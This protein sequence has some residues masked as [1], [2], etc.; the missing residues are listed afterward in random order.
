MLLIQEAFSPGAGRSGV[1]AGSFLA[2]ITIFVDKSARP[3]VCAVQKRS[4]IALS[5]S[6]RIKSTMP[7]PSVNTNKAS[8]APDGHVQENLLPA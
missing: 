4:S 7:C 3:S 8:V 2:E 5:A 6:F 1:Q